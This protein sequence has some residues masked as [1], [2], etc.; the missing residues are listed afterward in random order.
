MNR[1]KFLI[2]AGAAPLPLLAAVPETAPTGGNKHLL[3][4]QDFHPA[5]FLRRLVTLR[6][7]DTL[8]AG[9]DVTFATMAP[10]FGGYVY[11]DVLDVQNRSVDAVA[12][13]ML[14]VLRVPEALWQFDPVQMGPA[15]QVSE[16]SYGQNIQQHSAPGDPNVYWTAG[17]RFARLRYAL[18][19]GGRFVFEIGRNEKGWETFHGA[20]S[21]WDEGEWEDAQVLR[22]YGSL[23]DAAFVE[24]RF[25]VT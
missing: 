16:V 14:R 7:S 25:D 9:G 18:P 15:L 23:V 1:R 17:S 3:A 5:A 20:L 11:R 8:V 21:G 13:A 2:T 6:R 19:D 4:F 10:C 12:R 22:A 24:C